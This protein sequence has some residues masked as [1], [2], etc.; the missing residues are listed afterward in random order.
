M[1]LNLYKMIIKFTHSLTVPSLVI[2]YFM[3]LIPDTILT[4]DLLLITKWHDY[5]KSKEK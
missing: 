4:F 5:Y 2:K 1:A 3:L